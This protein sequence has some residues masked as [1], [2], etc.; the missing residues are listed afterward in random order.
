MKFGFGGV[1]ILLLLLTSI[2][3]SSRTTLLV[4]RRADSIAVLSVQKLRLADSPKTS[5][6]DRELQRI[7]QEELQH[8][9]I[10]I[11]SSTNAEFV[12]QCCM[13]ETWSEVAPESEPRVEPVNIYQRNAVLVGNGQ[14]VYQESFQ[15]RVRPLRTMY[16]PVTAIRMALYSSRASGLARLTPIWDGY[17]E[18][19]SAKTPH[20]AQAC[21]ELV[22]RIGTDFY[23]RIRLEE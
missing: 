23:G 3:C 19:K 9:Q 11:E 7:V 1:L 13:D 14:T 16:Y 5:A 18:A 2:G 21:R 4:A 15:P 10:G 17:I 12:L 20:I 8:A 22:A 6:G